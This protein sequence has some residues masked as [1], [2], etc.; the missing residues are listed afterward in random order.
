[1]QSKKKKITLSLDS[2]TL[3]LLEKY[4]DKHYLGSKSQAIRVLVKK[5][6]EKENQ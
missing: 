3:T 4:A 1:M 6:A 5:D 2:E